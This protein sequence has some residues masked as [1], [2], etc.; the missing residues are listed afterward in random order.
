MGSS[1]QAW[2]RY[3]RHRDLGGPGPTIGG[4][5]VRGVHPTQFGTPP[6]PCL[7]L[8]RVALRS[9]CQAAAH[10]QA[11]CYSAPPI[12]AGQYPPSPS[13]LDQPKGT[14]RTKPLIDLGS[15]VAE[16]FAEIGSGGRLSS[17]SCVELPGTV[18]EPT[19]RSEDVVGGGRQPGAEVGEPVGAVGGAR[20]GGRWDRL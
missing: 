3:L 13:V 10:P 15:G 5:S 19:G 4:G 14:Q 18:A 8:Q 20:P 12:H 7:P 6:L 9:I 17:E 16:A 1:V 2:T 11:S